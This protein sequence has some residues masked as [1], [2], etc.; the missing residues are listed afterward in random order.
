MQRKTIFE[1]STKVLHETRIGLRPLYMLHSS[2]SLH[3]CA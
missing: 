2:S 3:L 1:Y